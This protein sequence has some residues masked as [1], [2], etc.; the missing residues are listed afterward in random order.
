MIKQVNEEGKANLRIQVKTSLII[1]NGI[2]LI[3]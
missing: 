3:A 1:L 2:C